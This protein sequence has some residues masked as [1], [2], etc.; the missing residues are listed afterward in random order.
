MHRFTLLL[1]TCRLMHAL[2]FSRSAWLVL[3]KDLQRRFIMEA[4]INVSDL[5]MQELIDLVKRIISG[6]ETWSFG[7]ACQVS[8]R[9]VL[10][11]GF[12]DGALTGASEAKLLPD[13]RYVLF[14]NRDRLECWDVVRDTL[15]WRHVSAIANHSV[16]RFAAQTHP[17][18][19]GDSLLLLICGESREDHAPKK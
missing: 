17:A 8:R 5:S 11:P 13:G 15:V 12:L 3:V 10:H 6:P 7:L 4:D 2:A 16:I 18:K 9:V 14:K 1:Q 19:R